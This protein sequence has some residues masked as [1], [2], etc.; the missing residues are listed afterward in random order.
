MYEAN[1]NFCYFQEYPKSQE[2]F[3]HFRDTPIET[4]REDV[5]LSQ[6]LQE[7]AVRVMQVVEKA[8]GRL[9][10]LEKVRGLV[11]TMRR[12]RCQLLVTRVTSVGLESHQ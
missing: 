10:N 8:I 11:G 3:S 2:F 9:D 12:R 5:R 6:A 4:L 7:H 1:F